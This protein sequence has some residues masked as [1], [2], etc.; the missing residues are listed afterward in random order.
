MAFKINI[1]QGGLLIFKCC[2]VFQNRG[3]KVCVLG[4]MGGVGQPLSLLLKQSPWFEEA[5]L[6]DIK[7]CKGL[8]LELNQIDTPCKVTA[9]DCVKKALKSSNII[10]NVAGANEV[11]RSSLS[12]TKND[13]FEI[14]AKAVVETCKQSA[15]HCPESFHIIVTSPI[16]SMV[17]LAMEVYKKEN[18]CVEP[19][20]FFGLTLV[21][22]MRA[23]SLVADITQSSA[24]DVQIPVIGGHSS[25]TTVPLLSRA[26]PSV[27]LSTDET[28]RV[29]RAVQSANEDVWSAKEGTGTPVLA[30]AFAGI[31][32]AESLA[33]ALFGQKGVVECTYVMSN[34][35]P[36]ISFFASPVELGPTGIQK[37][38]PLPNPLS[39]FEC[40]LLE[41]A[42]GFL[43]TDIDKG[44]KF[45]FC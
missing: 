41:S 9:Y 43:K 29:V 17:P 8:A 38:L 34:I 39:N 35:I 37:I 5:S 28:V 42:L 13:L 45:K 20:R 21:D 7:D 15:Q 40:C 19:G 25:M 33:K 11:L 27:N 26:T 12:S 23:S 24:E 18:N 2:S 3:L 14:N 1:F 22:V 44:K 32:M 10:I 4:A 30:T 16:N 6:Y 31:R 36:H